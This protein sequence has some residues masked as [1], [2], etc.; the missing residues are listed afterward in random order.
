M[1]D[2]GDLIIAIE[3]PANVEARASH[4]LKVR[5]RASGARYTADIPFTGVA[6][7]A[8]FYST[9]ASGRIVSIE[10]AAAENAPG[11]LVVLTHKNMPRMN[12]V[13]WSH[14]H[15]Q[16]QLAQVAADALGLTPERVTVRLGDT[17]YL[18]I[19]TNNNSLRAVP[20]P[21]T[22]RVLPLRR[23]LSVALPPT[24]LR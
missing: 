2:R 8:I 7:A 17:S 14:L 6:H 11:V 5:D 21:A 20:A 9:I 15:P 18:G 10:T 12:P 13:P 19:R 1:L 3:V 4:Y 24:T 16:G 22:R 23:S